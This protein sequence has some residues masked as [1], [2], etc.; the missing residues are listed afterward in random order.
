MSSPRAN[1]CATCVRAGQKQSAFKRLTAAVLIYLTALTPLS[2]F[3]TEPM[4]SGPAIG[5]SSSR[6]ALGERRPGIRPAAS[7]TAS[8]KTAFGAT[9]LAN[10]QKGSQTL[11]AALAPQ[12]ST[13][14]GSD[15][16]STNSGITASTNIFGPTK[17]L[18]TE[19]PP[20][21]YVTTVN[22]PAWV[23]SPFDL[24]IQNGAADGC[25]RV[26]SPALRI[27]TRTFL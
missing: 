19:G 26:S 9:A 8:G 13:A 17:Y 25:Y 3:G 7:A 22:V 10:H 18:R 2:S 4:F 1:S 16:V 15:A 5:Y 14:A 20:N 27:L 12:D 6:A 11:V 23:A 24:H 21:D